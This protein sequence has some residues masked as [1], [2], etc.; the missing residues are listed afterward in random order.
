VEF[1]KVER[2]AIYRVIDDGSHQH[3]H[4]D[5]R[6]QGGDVVWRHGGVKMD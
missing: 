5:G 1:K 2:L 3:M 4:I 6:A